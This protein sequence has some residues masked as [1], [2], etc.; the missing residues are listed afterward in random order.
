MTTDMTSLATKL[1]ELVVAAADAGGHAA[2]SH[3]IDWLVVISLFTNAL[4]FFGF[5][6]WQV[7]PMVSKG[8]KERRAT[9]ATELE[10]AQKKQAEAEA[11]LAEYQEKLDNLEREVSRVIESY[12]REAEA[13][14]KR[15]EEDT[16]KAVARMLRETE[17]TINQ[18][19]RKAE[20]KIHAAAVEA[21]LQAAE[22][23]IRARIHD[24]DHRRLT[25]QYVE[26]LRS[27]T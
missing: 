4:L 26:S 17:F 3:G 25:D 21:T 16:E 8:L 23:K 12:E 6:F 24:D 15:F 22:Q 10:R 19:M 20:R 11:R 9:M 27:E 1:G 13:D 5:L 2:E 7:A 18:E 14:R